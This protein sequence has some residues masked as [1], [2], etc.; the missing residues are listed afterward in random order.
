MTNAIADANPLLDK[1]ARTLS[2]EALRG[3]VM[4]TMLFVN[5]VGGVHGLP[6]WM[7]H[8]D[9]TGNNGMTFVD[10]VF[11]GFLFVV[12]V[13]IPL[14][15][16][17]RLKRNEP[18][19][20]LGLHILTR[21]CGLLLL[22]V[23]MVNGEDGRSPDPHHMGFSTTLWHLILCSSAILAFLA[24]ISKTRAAK[25][26]N[27]ILRTLGF[28]GLAFVA[29]VY[30]TKDGRMAHPLVVGNSRPHRL[31]VSCRIDRLSRPAQARMAR[32][33]H[34]FAHGVF[35]VRSHRFFRKATQLRCATFAL[36]ALAAQLPEL[37]RRAG[38][39]TGDLDGRRRP[40]LDAARPANDRPPATARHHRLGLNARDRGGAVLSVLPAQQKQ[41]HA[42]V[43]LH[44]RRHHLLAVGRIFLAHR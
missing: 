2:V 29:A 31:G 7:K 34:V 41:R 22:G 11:G 30:R 10:W 1:P 4:L 40:R 20:K 28:A 35:H 43:V 42:D 38:L 8:F 9:E 14:A 6:W 37:R 44:P 21:T 39:A 27:I 16:A 26:T 32:R 25:I 3:F 36:F 33:R 15:F 23:L 12:G 17:N 5:D 24:P 13:S 19:W 18:A